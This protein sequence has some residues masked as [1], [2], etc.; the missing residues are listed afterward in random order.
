MNAIALLRYQYQFALQ[1]LESTVDTV[2]TEEACCKPSG[3]ANSIGANFAH[4]VLRQDLCVNA[5]LKGGAALALSSWAG[6]TGISEPAI[7]PVP[8]SPR[9]AD[10]HDWAER[11]QVD[12]S[13]LRE[14]ARAV[15]A[16]TDGYL[17]TLDEGDLDNLVDLS[18]LGFGRQPVSYLLNA[19]LAN[20]NHHCGEISFAKGL[21]G[22]QG[23]SD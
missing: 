22:A 12:L 19:N 13:Q 1:A 23:Y 17:S 16:A 15:F 18:M 7:G 5:L 11:V 14:F 3:Q 9:F 6:R 4:V 21:R 8:E 20:A 2:T 10:D